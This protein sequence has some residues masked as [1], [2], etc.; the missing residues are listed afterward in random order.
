MEYFFDKLKNTNLTV[1]VKWKCILPKNFC[2]ATEILILIET[3]FLWSWL[4][5]WTDH[6]SV[7]D[8]Y[9]L[10]ICADSVLRLYDKLPNNLDVYMSEFTFLEHIDVLYW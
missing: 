4:I 7:L 2:S 6:A 8:Q 5:L 3:L 9:D 1:L 10:M